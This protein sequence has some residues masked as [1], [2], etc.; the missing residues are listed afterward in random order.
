MALRVI[1]HNGKLPSEGGLRTAYIADDP[2]RGPVLIP[3]ANPPTLAAIIAM[4]PYVPPEE[5][6]VAPAKPKLLR[7]SDIVSYR[8]VGG[9]CSKCRE[10]ISDVNEKI[11]ETDQGSKVI[12]YCPS[13]NL[14]VRD[15]RNQWD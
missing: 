5:T 4:G 2:E 7:F 6:A 1:T 3:I 8:T 11:V 13:C 14:L 15:W 10:Y 9:R 12:H